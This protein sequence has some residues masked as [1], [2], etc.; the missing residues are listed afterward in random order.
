MLFYSLIG[1][2]LV[3]FT[4]RDSKRFSNFLIVYYLVSNRARVQIS[5]S[6]KTMTI[7]K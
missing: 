2:Y 6:E 3:H 1:F 5:V 4:D 7:S